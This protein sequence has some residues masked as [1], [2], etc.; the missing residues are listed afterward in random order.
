MS[1]L[2]DV[3]LLHIVDIWLDASSVSNDMSLMLIANDIK[4]YNSFRPLDTEDIYAF[5]RVKPDCTIGKLRSHH[6]KCVS[7]IREYISYLDASG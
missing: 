7:N 4:T 5:E 1:T 3:P 2:Y 6:A